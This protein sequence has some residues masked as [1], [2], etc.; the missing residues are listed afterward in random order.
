MGKRESGLFSPVRMKFLI[1]PRGSHRRIPLMIPSCASPVLVLIIYT[2][3]TP[4]GTVFQHRGESVG[5][6]EIDVSKNRGKAGRRDRAFASS[7][8]SDALYGRLYFEIIKARPVILLRL[9]WMAA[10][11]FD[12]VGVFH[13]VSSKWL[14]CEMIG[15]TIKPQPWN[16]FPKQRS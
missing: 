15:V 5:P 16:A 11:I 13:G 10:N 6:R 3:P 14:H 2:R 8:G 7:T 9:R 4:A 1:R 12:G